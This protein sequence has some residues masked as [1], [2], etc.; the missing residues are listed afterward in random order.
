[1]LQPEWLAQWFERYPQAYL[2]A[3]HTGLFA[4]VR[5]QR[6]RQQE[7]SL[8]EARG[9]PALRR[10]A[11]VVPRGNASQPVLAVGTLRVVGNEDT[12]LQRPQSAFCTYFYDD[13]PLPGHP[14]AELTRSYALGVGSEEARGAQASLLAVLRALHFYASE[15][16][17]DPVLDPFDWVRPVTREAA[18]EV[19]VRPDTLLVL[20]AMLA[21]TA[22]AFAVSGGGR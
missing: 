9:L 1:M 5:L 12:E 8:Y 15:N 7:R 20:P 11:E 10:L 21:R 3:M 18:G 14:H 17:T 2:Y 13:V 4:T 19:A 22:A 6:R 16:A